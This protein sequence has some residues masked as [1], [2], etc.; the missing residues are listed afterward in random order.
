MYIPKNVCIF[1]ANSF[2][3]AVMVQTY[4][5][6]HTNKAIYRGTFAPVNTD[7]K[8]PNSA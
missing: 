2:T 3:S 4:Y 6:F 8:E 1:V 5:Y 7:I